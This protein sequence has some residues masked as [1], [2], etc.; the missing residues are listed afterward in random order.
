M[1]QRKH[2]AHGAHFE[3]T[4]SYIGGLAN[5]EFKTKPCQNAEYIFP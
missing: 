4:C 2:Y 5:I 3:Q 1:K